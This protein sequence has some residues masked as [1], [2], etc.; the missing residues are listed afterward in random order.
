MSTS[1]E[2]NTPLLHIADAQLRYG[3]RI[4]WDHLT[5]EVKPGEL[6]A[7]LGPNG[8]G[9]STLLRAIQ[10]LVPLSKGKITVAGKP[11][12]LGNNAIGYIPQQKSLTNDFPIRGRDLVHLGLT[13]HKWGVGLPWHR[14][15]E[16]QQV[17]NALE[18]VD[19]TAFADQIVGSLSG[20]EQQRIRVAQ[21]LVSKPQLL[22]CDEPLLSLDPAQQQRFMELVDKQRNTHGTAILFVTHEINPVLPYTDRVLY[23]TA[24]GHRCGTV[25][26]VMNSETLTELYGSRITVVEVD[27][28]LVMVGAEKYQ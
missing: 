25:S 1:S 22:L 8:V 13:G 28:Q 11:A 5:M 10:G 9:K 7:I 21:A 27:G 20:G 4:L 2:N 12:H 19:A 17:Q 15:K 18:E 24:S 16:A 3:E 14:K 23:L 6:V 26:E